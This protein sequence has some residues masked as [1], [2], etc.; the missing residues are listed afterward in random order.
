[1]QKILGP[2]GREFTFLKRLHWTEN[3]VSDNFPIPVPG[4]SKISILRDGVKYGPYNEDTLRKYFAQGLISSEDQARF[5][6]LE[7]G[8]ISRKSVSGTKPISKT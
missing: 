1:M 8:K 6:G 4:G 3:K 7:G 5:D 2:E